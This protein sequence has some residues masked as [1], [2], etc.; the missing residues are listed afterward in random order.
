VKER[1]QSRRVQMSDHAAGSKGKGE[2]KRKQTKTTVE[3][4]A[5]EEG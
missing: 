2:K 1:E 5:N 4:Q 3:A